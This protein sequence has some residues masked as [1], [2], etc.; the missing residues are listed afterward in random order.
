MLRGELY[1]G[2]LSALVLCDC[3]HVVVQRS[4]QSAGRRLCGQRQA[5]TSP[6][7]AS[8]TRFRNWPYR[9][10]ARNPRSRVMPRSTQTI[11]YLHNTRNE[12]STIMPPSPPMLPT[13]QTSANQTYMEPRCIVRRSQGYPQKLAGLHFLCFWWCH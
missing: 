2:K 7:T 10:C 4:N 3:Q 1:I 9:V 13:S 8:V 12:A 6:V 5:D 11:A